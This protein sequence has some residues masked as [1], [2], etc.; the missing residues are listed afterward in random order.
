MP[1][2]AAAYN[3]MMIGDELFSAAV[4]ISRDP[5]RGGFLLAQEFGKVFALVCILLGVILN[6]CGIGWFAKFLTS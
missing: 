6:S 2:L 1:F 4:Y 3:Q 5:V